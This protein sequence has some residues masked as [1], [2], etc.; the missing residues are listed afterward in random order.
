MT[1]TSKN[2]SEAIF[3]IPSTDFEVYEGFLE[4]F[5]AGVAEAAENPRVEDNGRISAGDI[6]GRQLEITREGDDSVESWK[7]DVYEAFWADLAPKMT[8][9][10]A[11][12]KMW[13]GLSLIAAW[14]PALASK[15]VMNRSPAMALGVAVTGLVL[16]FWYI[17][18]FAIGL[19]ALAD[20]IAAATATTA[21]GEGAQ[22]V[23]G[24]KD[25]ALYDAMRLASEHTAVVY[26]WLSSIF[27]FTFL[28]V[29]RIVDRTFTVRQYVKVNN[30]SVRHRVRSRVLRRLGVIAEEP[31][32]Q[33]ITIVAPGFGSIVAI[34]LLADI[35]A[36][37]FPGVRIDLVTL[38]SQVGLLASLSKWV[39]TEAKKMST[40]ENSVP[41]A[42][43]DYHVVG[44]WSGSLIKNC[45]VLAEDT[46]ID[47]VQDSID[48]EFLERL[49]LN[50]HRRYWRAQKI[51]EQ[52]L[53][54]T[55]AST[56][57]STIPEPDPPAIA[58]ETTVEPEEKA[59]PEQGEQD[60][61]G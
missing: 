2:A 37:R 40:G 43:Q 15:N 32:Y 10:G 48:L 51:V 5:F 59:D 49:M 1:T 13:A 3:L 52:I 57:E 23:A 27:I 56:L 25:T 28:P 26:A 45:G 44:D 21:E 12:T 53:N 60:V 18:V 6:S 14:L 35:G 47:G 50:A 16:C 34:D 24:F 29:D 46:Q 31:S 7:V 33:R 41:T 17:G 20:T 39:L 42:W 11:T 4:D 19:N 54:A 9:E 55:H 58:G 30:E 38:G 8:A 22:A 36:A 61:D